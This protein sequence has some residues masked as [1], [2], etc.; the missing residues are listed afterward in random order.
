MKQTAVTFRQAKGQRKLVML[1][2]YDATVDRKS[3]V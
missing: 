3:V 2:A 1:T